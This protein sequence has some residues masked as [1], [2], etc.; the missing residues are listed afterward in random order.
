MEQD[1]DVMRGFDDYCQKKR[2]MIMEM[3]D[4][5]QKACQEKV[6]V[7]RSLLCH[8]AEGMASAYAKYA[9]VLVENSDL[10]AQFSGMHEAVVGMVCAG[11]E[12]T[13]FNK[14]KA[15]LAD[16]VCQ[17]QSAEQTK[18]LPRFSRSCSK[19]L[20]SIDI[21][22]SDI[23]DEF[24]LIFEPECIYNTLVLLVTTVKNYCEFLEGISA[25]Q[26]NAAKKTAR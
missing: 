8:E 4:P 26:Q 12:D 17:V 18:R 15:N 14:W 23:E 10:S 1:F 3:T 7:A 5:E 6:L 19:V 9:D 13:A 25:R 2:K 24:R 11:L 22:F 20:D 16:A 21:D